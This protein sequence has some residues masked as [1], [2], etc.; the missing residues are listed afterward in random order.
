MT[1]QYHQV[2]RFDWFLDGAYD[3]YQT[4]HRTFL[5]STDGHHVSGP[6]T[7]TRYN[8]DGSVRALFCGSAMSTRL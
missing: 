1:G 6:I 4:V 8:A 7:T 2:V 3:G 5:M